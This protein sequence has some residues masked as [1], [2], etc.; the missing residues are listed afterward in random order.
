MMKHIGRHDN[1]RKGGGAPAAPGQTR[2]F[3]HLIERL[4]ELYRYREL[5]RNLVASELKARYKNSTLGFLWSLLNP[6]GMML[7][8]T[9]VFGVIMPNPQ[10]DKYPLFLLCGLLPWNFFSEGVMGSVNSVVNN[11]NLIKK[12]YFPREV[13]PIAGVLAQ[14]V[15]F[16]LA[17]VILF[18]ALL[19][20]RA[21]FSPW[22]WMLPI[23]ILVQTCFT[24]G[25]AL[26][27]STLNV[28]YRDTVLIMNVVMLAW[29]FLTPI[30][31][32]AATLPTSYTLYGVEL[33]VRR[34]LFIFNPVASLVNLYQDLLYWGSRTDFDFFW[35]TVVTA[36]AVLVLGYWVFVRYSDRFGEE[37]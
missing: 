34:L 26:I 33:N 4:R 24:I 29:F 5:I 20:F 32:A 18:V 10:I 37:L 35:R 30:F 25:I 11:A 16:L 8:F 36:L 21:S 2:P 3:P 17:F 7:V 12:V 19:I 14:L 27:L 28:F 13:L 23:L 6:L 22:L 31:Y 1:E 9:I 15:N